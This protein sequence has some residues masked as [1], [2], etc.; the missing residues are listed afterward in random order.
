MAS[1]PPA[2]VSRRAGRPSR[3]ASGDG[4]EVRERLLDA[5]TSFAIERG[6]DATGIREIAERA[7]VS[8]GMIAYY[9]GGRNG[10][11]E[12][13]FERAFERLSAQLSDA[14]NSPPPGADPI[15]SM[16]RIHSAAIA[17]N[18]W[19]PQL[20]ARE[21]LASEGSLREKFA[22]RVGS[23]PL[24]LMRQAI[25]DAIE[26]GL[27]R[28]DLDP[29]LCV[30]TLG[31][32]TAFPYL[33]A[34]VLGDRLGIELDDAFLKRLVEHNLALIARGLRAREEDVT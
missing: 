22:E 11:H 14:I 31:S 2:P 3:D 33:M 28:K 27:L 12:A 21:V 29:A 13:M 17:A 30:M 32:L 25:E 23:G 19:I 24:G 10:L 8:S 6:F 1:P 20:M 16:I 15:E 26:R 18:P 5:A 7:G 34:P 4:S 9:F